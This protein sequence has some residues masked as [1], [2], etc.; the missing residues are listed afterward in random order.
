MSDWNPEQYLLFK[1]ERTQAVVDLVS[2][3]TLEPKSIIDI[4]CG[5]GNSTQIVINRWPKADVVGLDNSSS[6]IEKAKKDYPEQKWV[7]GDANVIDSARKFDLVFSNATLQWLPNHEIL[8]PELFNA[9]NYNGALAV[10]IPKFKKM[11]INIAIETVANNSQWK[12]YTKGCG[13]LFTCNNMDF[14][15]DILSALTLKVEMWETHYYHILNSQD[16]LIDFCRT[17][18]MKPYL[19]R[20]PSNEMKSEFELD[21]LQECRKYYTVQSNGKVLFP[22]ERLFFIAYK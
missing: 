5:P 18:G 3:I 15:F 10:Q 6:M 13:E 17:T 19:D 16:A 14:Y 1:N 11:P 9:V 2:R 4:G 7:L 22:F 20:L 12:T 21:V 8:I